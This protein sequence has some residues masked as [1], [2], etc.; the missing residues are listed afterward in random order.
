MS[1]KIKFEDSYFSEEEMNQMSK[2]GVFEY[3]PNIPKYNV[4]RMLTNNTKLYRKAQSFKTK[5]ELFKYIGANITN[6]YVKKMFPYAVRQSL[7]HKVKFDIKGGAIPYTPVKSELGNMNSYSTYTSGKERINVDLQ[8]SYFMSNKSQLNY[9]D[10]LAMSIVHESNHALFHPNRLSENQLARVQKIFDFVQEQRG[11]NPYVDRTRPDSD[12]IMDNLEEFMTEG[13]SNPAFINY[14]DSIPYKDGRSVATKLFEMFM[15]YVLGMKV[16]PKHQTAYTHLMQNYVTHNQEN[17]D[18]TVKRYLSNKVSGEVEFTKDDEKGVY[19]KKGREYMRV[20]DL[21]RG[22]LSMFSLFNREAQKSWSEKRADRA[23]K[24]H[25]VG[26]ETFYTTPK[27]HK[28]TI[29][30]SNFTYDEYVAHLDKVIARSAGRGD[31]GHKTAE[32]AFGAATHADLKALQK[33]MEISP[34]IF[35]WILDKKE[36]VANKLGLNLYDTSV[37]H[38]DTLESEKT[39]FSEDMGWAGTIDLLVKHAGGYFSI[40][41]FKA[42]HNHFKTYTSELLKYGRQTSLISDNPHDRANL[43]TMIYAFMYKME[44]PKAKFKDLMIAWIP[45]EKA[46]FSNKGVN[47]INPADYL[48]LIKAH[49]KYEKPEL[50]AKIMREKPQVFDATEYS[51]G[52]GSK[53]RKAL[54]NANGGSPMAR[55]LEIENRIKMLLSISASDDEFYK[56]YQGYVSA[57]ENGGAEKYNVKTERTEE[58]LRLQEELFDLQKSTIGDASAFTEDMSKVS[59]II[60]NNLDAAHPFVRHFDQ[61]Y[62]NAKMTIEQEHTKEYGKFLRYLKPVWEAYAEKNNVSWKIPMTGIKFNGTNYTDLWNFAYVRD[63][64]NRILKIKSTP[65]EYKGLSQ[66]EINLLK[67]LNS[68][69]NRK[70][71]SDDAYYN[72]KS[73]MNKDEEKISPLELYNSL[74]EGPDFQKSKDDGF[75]ARIPMTKEEVRMKHKMTSS[76][77]WK[78]W[79]Y[80]NLTN[81]YEQSYERWDNS[82]EL[83]P[84]KYLR[85]TDNFSES[86]EH[87]FDQFLRSALQK[88]HMDTPFAVSKSI[89]HYAKLKVASKDNKGLV[90]VANYMRIQIDQLILGRKETELTGGITRNNASKFDLIKL[91]DGMI[92]IA[93]MIIMYVKPVAGL[94]KNAPMTALITYKTALVGSIIKRTNMVGISNH[95]ID[96]TLS[97][98]AQ[99][100]GNWKTMMGAKMR[101]EHYKNKEWLL[102]KHFR[103]FSDSMAHKSSE[104]SLLTARYKGFDSGL[105]YSFH[106]VPEEAFNAKVLFAQMRHAKVQTPEGE[107][108]LLDMYHVVEVDGVHQ[109]KWGYKNKDGKIINHKRGVENVS[110]DDAIPEYVDITELT[111]AEMENMKYNYQKILGAYKPEEKAAYKYYIMGRLFGQFKTFFSTHLKNAGQSRGTRGG[112][113]YAPKIDKNGDPVLKDGESILDWHE[114][115]SEGRFRLLLKFS[116]AFMGYKF[117]NENPK[118]T[119]EKAL[120]L[121]GGKGSMDHYRWEDLSDDDRRMLL[122]TVVTWSTWGAMA[123]GAA[124]MFADADED[125]ASKVLFG[126][127]LNE[128]SSEYFPGGYVDNLTNITPASV[129]LAQRQYEGMTTLLMSSAMAAAGDESAYTQEGNLKGLIETGNTLPFAAS[130]RDIDRYLGNAEMFNKMSLTDRIRQ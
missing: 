89:Q 10:K 29:D 28:L 51:T 117:R 36:A 24:S 94:G 6:E 120:N 95:I 59:A 42:G 22:V 90:N 65:E 79:Y 53:A 88:E 125:E 101:D 96:F 83:I 67:Y 43:Q 77:Y 5:N 62:K 12:Y 71:L 124:I 84:M 58:I 108:N 32:V 122:D 118:N 126:R 56:D 13:V 37:D 76:A 86:L 68:F 50:Y 64:H 100:T 81:F 44:N 15:E 26:D 66:A 75:F 104:T 114:R 113:Y 57:Q 85:D 70:L 52:Y 105:L 41:D 123:F 128:Y 110:K 35:S 40:I 30:G 39:I 129:R 72:K 16:S 99:A 63:E 115:V 2:K 8:Q 18:R 74:A 7:K 78:E 73:L 109:L 33:E 61:L 20:T 34:R 31:V 82:N 23:W 107:K 116:V 127:I 102:M 93:S 80:R 98:L 97:D 25:V 1:C 9:I 38:R 111:S 4:N 14:L 92:N 60:S 48:N 49:I 121:I 47:K 69:Y 46:F 54:F 106:S 55:K 112:G 21:M 27:D 130:Y 103:A 3:T 119:W 91:A 87:G 11:S 17:Q 45:T 19:I